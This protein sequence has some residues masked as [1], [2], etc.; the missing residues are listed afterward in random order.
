[1]PSVPLGLK[2][3]KRQSAFQPEVE[4][5]NL[6]LEPDDSGGSP[7]KFM[8]IQR[9]GLRRY[10][11]LG[12]QVKGVY[13]KEGV[14]SGA[15]FATAGGYLHSITGGISTRLG[16]IG[17]D[18]ATFAGTFDRIYALA[19]G[20]PYSWNGATQLLID[21]PE[22]NPAVDIETLNNYTIIGCDNG[23]FY[24]I[25][26]GEDQPDALDFASAESSPD[27]LI[28]V[29]RLVDEL[30]LFGKSG[31]EVWQTTGDG[32]LP[33]QRAAGRQFERGCMA[34]DTVRRFDNSVVW[35]GDDG[36]VPIRISDNGIEERIRSRDAAP[37]AWVLEVDGH[38]FYVLTIPGQG[39]FAFDASTSAWSEFATQGRTGW[40]GGYGI[41]DNGLVYA[42]DD[43]SGA[44]Y[45]VDPAVATDGDLPIRCAMSGSVA[46]QGRGAIVKSFSVGVGSSAGFTLRIRWKD[47]NEPWPAYY[48]EV[49]A[50]AGADIVTIYR[51]GQ[52][53]EPFRT[54]EV[55]SS[56]PV[57][58]RF[59]GAKV[60]EGWQ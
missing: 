17:Q 38:K 25:A 58:K 12:G 46:F 37:W 20:A 31:T 15:L 6:Y 39:C 52:A 30:W 27:G 11:S 24:W 53:N 54:F 21:I 34:R 36:P 43:R 44:I 40:M 48:E 5:V 18:A 28:A 60:N 14:L 10:V 35:V 3:Y 59:S 47:G 19:G 7:D 55:E 4:L 1:M 42:A 49:E 16:F 41:S 23:D 57:M 13:R 8:R 26:P 51:L 32:D 2:S 50:Q 29:R 9:P 22:P 33:F 45:T 56:D